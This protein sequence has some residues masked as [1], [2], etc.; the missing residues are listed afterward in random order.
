[1][2][3]R[4]SISGAARIVKWRD[5]H[6]IDSVFPGKRLT[7][8]YWSKSGMLFSVTRHRRKRVLRK[9]TLQSRSTPGAI[10]RTPNASYLAV[11]K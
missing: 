2:I 5:G 8:T 11:K 3:R 9:E 10:R 1:M 6:C 4:H 7:R